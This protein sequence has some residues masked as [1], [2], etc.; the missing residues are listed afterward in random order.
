VNPRLGGD[1]IPSLYQLA[2]GIDLIRATIQ[3]AVN[4]AP[5]FATTQS[6]AAAIQFFMPP[7]DGRLIDVL[8]TS[9]AGQFA[10][11]H[12]LCI[13]KTNGTHITQYGDFRDRLGHVIGVGDTLQQA[14]D[15]IG[16]AQECV[17]FRMA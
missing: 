3:N 6:R 11:V 16:R 15:A 9:A 10:G 4:Q 8:G 14:T 13:Y 7:R 5:D 12:E 1:L 2:L 17:N